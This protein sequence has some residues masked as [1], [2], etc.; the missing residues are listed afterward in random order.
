MLHICRKQEYAYYV[1]RDTTLQDK[2]KVHVMPAPQEHFPRIKVK[3]EAVDHANWANFLQR[4]RRLFAQSVQLVIMQI[5][6][7][8]V[9]ARR[10]QMA[11]GAMK[12]P[13]NLGVKICA[14]QVRGGIAEAAPQH[15][16]F[17]KEDM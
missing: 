17:A 3:L 8:P 5:M 16:G 2:I 7:V 1:Q 4:L 14:L 15:A 12:Q 9:N 6:K 13:K 11:L 10:A